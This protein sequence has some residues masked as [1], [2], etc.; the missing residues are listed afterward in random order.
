MYNIGFLGNCILL[1]TYN[2]QVIIAGGKFLLVYLVK[3]LVYFVKF[4][5]HHIY[6]YT[7]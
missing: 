7:R 3:K 2:F 4:K 6:A 5:V 1:F